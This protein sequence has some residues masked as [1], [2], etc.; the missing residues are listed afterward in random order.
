MSGPRDGAGRDDAGPFVRFMGA[1][2]SYGQ[3][4]PWVVLAC[5]LAFTALSG[6]YAAGNLKI[7]TDTAGMIS[8][9]LPFRQRYKAFREAFPALSDNVAIV[10]D[11]DLPD[12]ADE[13]T[14]I[15][16]AKLRADPE[17]F[18]LVFSPETNPFFLRNGLL[19][20][21]REALADLSD[22]I[23]ESQAF[24]VKLS[25]DPSLRG[26][27]AVLGDAVDGVEE[28]DQATR[29]ATVL[30]TLTTVAMSIGQGTP[31]ALS[32]R[33]L[34]GGE[35]D[36]G[37]T[38]RVIITQPRV[39]F[40]SLSPAAEAMERIRGIARQ[41]GLTPETGVTVRL[42]GGVVISTEELESVTTGAT[43]AGFVSLVLVTLLLAWGIRS[44]RLVL[45]ILAALIAGLVWTAGFT[46]L[47]IGHLNLVS[48]AF[49]V[50]FIGLGVDFGIHFALRF[51]EERLRD[52][53][54][55]GG[56]RRTGRGLAG[57]LALCALAAAISFFSFVPTDYRGLSELGLIAGVGMFIA[58]IATFTVIPA[59]L[60]V[61]PPGAP[62]SAPAA[63]KS[64]TLPDRRIAVAALILGGAAAATVPFARFDLDPIKL[65]D[66]STESV[67]T[68]RDLAATAGASP[69]TIELLAPSLSG[70]YTLAG[71]LRS[72]PEVDKTV[73]A[74]DLVPTEQTEKLAMIDDLNIF[75]APLRLSGTA[76]ELNAAD[77]K[78]AFVALREAL[79][80]GATR[81]LP[82]VAD[83]AAGAV[84]L[85]T[86]LAMLDD[87]A[88]QA[89]F[90]AAVFRHFSPQIE[91]LKKTL[92][93]TPVALKDLPPEILHRYLAPNGRARVQVYPSENLEDPEAL[94]RFVHA[95][96]TIA[97][98]A[99]DSPVEILEAGKAVVN[100]VVTAALISVVAVTLMIF[101]VLRSARDTLLVLIPLL[102]AALYTVAATVL[103]SMPF[104]FANVIV[105]PLLMG[106]GV[107][108]GIHLVS[109]ARE[110]SSG[111][112]AFSTTTP[113]AV[114]FSSLTTIASFGSLAVSSHRGTA[115]MG[116]L[117]V[118]SI[119][120][121]LICTLV[122]LPALMQ[123]WP[124]GEAKA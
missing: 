121:T 20:L 110:E 112:A 34:I 96:R 103:L 68:F 47:A 5:A 85:N 41:A 24:L 55:Q 43:N 122:V 123:L 66:P 4:S 3:M 29:L 118:L 62:A 101:L 25:G 8:E 44:L 32:W 39:D 107:A 95:V 88:K 31:V 37:T 46:T 33:A 94:K 65:R 89:A 50:L 13:A 113:R 36:E 10:V 71:K 40:S 48:V 73:T 106:L 7:D 58:F 75:L 77:R 83:L 27:A 115:S 17:N 84:R 54:P 100:S 86:A 30:D 78:K 6:F 16:A 90:E 104:N 61:F 70:A 116:E 2:V 19:Y 74:T 117:L 1:V 92:D 97:P 15:L 49:A 60:T 76:A 82:A 114:I 80:Q 59:F 64:P 51:R 56:L 18:P 98:D 42:T 45:G 26:L 87:G 119:G 38:R 72:L 11:A 21:D 99:T 52:G 93:A 63:R 28:K 53:D 35:Q 105:L 102:L 12:R 109:R 111:A 14:E 81:D 23:A 69:Y 79:A 67:R 22:E 57:P 91:R 124:D 120:L 108:N 9:D